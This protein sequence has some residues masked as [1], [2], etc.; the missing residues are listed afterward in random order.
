MSRVL[1]LQKCFLGNCCE[2]P[3]SSLT[4]LHLLFSY[5]TLG[6]WASYLFTG[7]VHLFCSRLIL[8]LTVCKWLSSFWNSF[9]SGLVGSFLEHWLSGVCF[10]LLLGSLCLFYWFGTWVPE[11]FFTARTR[12]VWCSLGLFQKSEVF[13]WKPLIKSSLLSN[14]LALV[15]HEQVGYVPPNVWCIIVVNTFI[16]ILS[17][18]G[19]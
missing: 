13:S 11:T 2:L 10:S 14:Y 3:W 12:L 9:Q 5:G 4:T 1:F 17:V 15:S 18:L 7:A 6:F 8:Y 19:F 16:I